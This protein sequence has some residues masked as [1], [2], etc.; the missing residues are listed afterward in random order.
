MSLK[1]LRMSD[2]ESVGL[3]PQAVIGYS[4]DKLSNHLGVEFTHGHDAFDEYIGA[5]FALNNDLPF[6]VMRYK[7]HPK[8]T[9]TLYL[10]HQISD[11][12]KITSLISDIVSEM[13]ISREL[14]IW[15][16]ANDPD[17]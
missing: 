8:N 14:L 4:V 6:A 10:P 13:D 3:L 17:L 5:A 9:V 12:S 7:G 2:V 1:N 15:Q 16:R 11:I